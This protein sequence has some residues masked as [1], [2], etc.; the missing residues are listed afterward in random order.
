MPVIVCIVN[1]CDLHQKI[2]IRKNNDTQLVTEAETAQLASLLVDVAT[3]NYISDI[4]LWGDK[5]YLEVIKE[6]LLEYESNL[7]VYINE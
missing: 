2:Y 5:T 6:E 7:K 1:I 3:I 4:H